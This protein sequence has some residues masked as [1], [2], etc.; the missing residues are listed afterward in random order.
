[1]NSVKM[2]VCISIA[3]SS[4]TVDFVTTAHDDALFRSVTVCLPAC[5]QVMSF[6]SQPRRIEKKFKKTT[7]FQRDVK[8][9]M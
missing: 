1:M 8:I 7:Q 9:D 2:F 3:V 6:T 5:L 4:L